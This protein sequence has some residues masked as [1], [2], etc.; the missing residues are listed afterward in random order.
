MGW[1]AGIFV[2]QNV[3]MSSPD[4]AAA[5]TAFTALECVVP[6]SELSQPES[7]RAVGWRCCGTLVTDAADS[8]RACPAVPA[9]AASGEA[10]ACGGPHLSIFP[11]SMS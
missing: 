7:A 9:D 11:G 5:A 8:L 6:M 2:P 4:A 1:F 10:A 3:V